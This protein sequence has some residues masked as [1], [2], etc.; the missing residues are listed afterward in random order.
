ME[1]TVAVRIGVAERAD[2][3]V[4]KELMFPHTFCKEQEPKKEK[5]YILMYDS[6][7]SGRDMLRV[8]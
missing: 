7:E 8:E 1:D 6:F 2:E 5:A 4:L 3:H